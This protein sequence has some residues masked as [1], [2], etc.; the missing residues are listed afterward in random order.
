[1]IR[2][3][4][5][6]L[7]LRLVLRLAILYVVT[8]ALVLGILIYRAY[9]TAGTLNDRELSLR[10]ADLAKHVSVDASGG[11]HLDLPP[12]LRSEY[13]SGRGADIF[14]IRR[15]GNPIVAASPPAFGQ[16]VA[17]WPNPTDDP[18]YF[19]LN[20]LGESARGLLWPQYR[21]SQCC[22]TDLH[23]R[24]PCGR[25]QRLIQSLLRE[26]VLDIAWLI[27]LLF[28]VTLGIGAVAISKRLGA[29]SQS[30]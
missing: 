29:H 6:S 17:G 26:F 11:A 20:S 19:R 25:R 27:P 9:E 14:A 1:M 10:A 28:L 21:A 5:G 13:E 23:L 3:T 30:L 12:Q 2:T 24:G 18:S 22:G 4:R 15:P 8:T 16:I 7:Q